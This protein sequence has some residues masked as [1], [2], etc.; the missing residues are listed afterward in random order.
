MKVDECGTK[1][2]AELLRW[3]GEYGAHLIER[4]PKREREAIA[5][6]RRPKPTPENALRAMA[7]SYAHAWINESEDEDWEGYLYAVRE[8]LRECLLRGDPGYMSQ[9]VAADYQARLNGDIPPDAPPF[10]KPTHGG[11]S[12]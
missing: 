9:D 5:A 4:L 2:R 8:A 6:Q 10:T 11:K 7:A 3:A 12:G 1:T